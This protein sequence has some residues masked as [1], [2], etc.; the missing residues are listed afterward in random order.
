MAEFLVMAKSNTHSD[1]NKDQTGCYKRGDIVVVKPDGHEWGKLEGLPNFVVIKVPGLNHE[2]ATKYLDPEIDPLDN[3]KRTSRR[4]YR[5]RVDDIPFNIRKQLQTTGTT[6]VEL[7]VLKNYL[8]HKKT[9]VNESDV[10][11]SI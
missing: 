3:F 9:L 5:I 1:P 7:S 4:K 8:Q 10:P 2:V 11:E 6:T